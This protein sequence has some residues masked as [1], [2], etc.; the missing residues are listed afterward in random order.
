VEVLR[1]YGFGNERTS[2]EDADFYKAQEAR[3]F[4]SPALI[5]PVGT[6][7]RVEV[8]PLL[9]YSRTDDDQRNFLNATRPYGTGEFGQVGVHGA[10]QLDSRDNAQYPRRGALLAAS[11]TWW[12]RVWDVTRTFGEMNA[13]GNAYL[14]LGSWLTLAARGGGKR[15]LGDAP[16]R[17]A[18]SIGGGG[19]ETGTLLEPGFELRGFRARRFAGDGALYG[20]TDLRL[21]LFRA[22]I[23]VPSHFGVFGL[24][25][26][27]RVWLEGEDSETWHTSVGGG[28]WI[29]A[30][31]YRRTFTAYIAHGREGN[32][33]RAGSGFTF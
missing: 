10:V 18:A 20:N 8:S 12:P 31:N 4:V 21:R 17:D 7:A 28:I 14:S 3:A 5:Y 32:I 25:D 15:V 13:N 29:S 26:A 24:A 23:L 1:Y 30:L 27:G 22:T 33:L 11:G 19:P 6:R 9:L 16:Y 2:A